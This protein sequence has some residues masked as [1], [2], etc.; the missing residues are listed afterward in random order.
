MAPPDPTAG[1]LLVGLNHR[2]ASLALRERFY[3]D[4]DAL[5]RLQARV[6]S[7]GLLESIVFSTCDRLEVAVVDQDLPAAE[8]GLIELLADWA[9]VEADA[10][11]QQSYRHRGTAA[12]RHLFA[13]AAS[14]DSQVIGEP[15]ILGQV[16]E[17]HRRALVAGTS[18]PHLDAIM[19]ATFGTAK[20][21]RHETSLAEQ[22]VTIAASAI[23]V[24]RN[25]HGDL[26]GCIGLLAGLAEIGELLALEFKEAGLG[27]LMVSHTHEHQAEAVAR[28]LT[29]NLVSWE[30]LPE[31]LAEA[32]I[33]I[34]A[35]GSGRY[36]L[37]VAQ[38]RDL[39]RQRR[40]KPI[41]LIDCRG[42]AG[43]RSG[44]RPAGRGFR[45]RPGRPGE[46]GAKRPGQS[47]KPVIRRLGGPRPRARWLSAPLGGAHC[48]SGGNLAA[49]T[50]RTGAAGDSRQGSVRSGDRDP[51]ADKPPA[52][53]SERGP[54]KGC[55]HGRWRRRGSRAEYAKAV[56]DRQRGTRR[57]G[58][59][60]SLEDSL[61][62]VSGAL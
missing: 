23:Q 18:G 17:S 33:I 30:T 28:R 35:R 56:Q 25:L 21:V 24:A 1:L 16:K 36:S 34:A 60:V 2:S 38:V 26:E 9:Q 41:F 53:R 50:F 19:Q 57:G 59:D 47:A 3:L 15:Q 27:H 54:A 31:S 40:Q 20:R 62:R 13:V 58:Q 7:L 45:L 11:D 32:D 43:S 22:P 6:Q 44:D 29:C 61:E 52:A 42:A 51:S 37:T 46:G 4:G 14:L 5:D 10:V 12:L 49:R 8:T 55:R 48:E 39:L